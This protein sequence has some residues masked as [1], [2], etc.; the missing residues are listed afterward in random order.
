VRGD[1][2][3]V[4]KA[5]S[6]AVKAT[7]ADHSFQAGWLSNL[8]IWL[9]RP[10]E[11]TNSK[12]DY[13]MALEVNHNPSRRAALLSS[14]GYNLFR[15]AALTRSGRDLDHSIKI[16]SMAVE[17]AHDALNWTALSGNLGNK[18]FRRDEWT[19]EEGDLNRA[20]EV[21]E[22]A[23][24]TTL[25]KHRFRANSLNNLCLCLTGNRLSGRGIWM[26]LIGLLRSLKKP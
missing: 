24:K 22:L 1:L 9:D 16:N 26:M 10:C 8:R 17:A 3:R 14:L 23:A 13:D 18:P 20:C 25:P 5:T 12:G 6:R 7:P 15:R 21:T 19:R 4:I 11:L 2:D